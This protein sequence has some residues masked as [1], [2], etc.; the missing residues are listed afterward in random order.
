MKLS[1]VTVS[2]NSADL[3]ERLADSA[4]KYPPSCEWELIIVDN[5]SSDFDPR[6]FERPRVRTLC[7]KDNAKYAKGNNLGAA[8]ARGEYLL[9]VNPDI[10][11]TPGSADILVDF[12]DA[13][14]EYGAACPRLILPDGTTDRSVR[15]FPYLLP[16]VLS[17]F[18]IPSSYMLPFMD[19]GRECDVLQP[20]TSSLLIRKEIFDALGGFDEAFPIFFNDVDLLYRAHERNIRIRYL[21]A[22][23]MKHVHGGSTKRAD[24]ALML[25]ES[26]LSLI[27]FYKKHWTKR[28]GKPLIA[29][30]EAAIKLVIPKEKQQ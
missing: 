18:R 2:W 19:Y 10:E 9:L 8:M 26:R 25:R 3:A 28:Y 23:R 30:F 7:L 27:R 14:S 6:R 17:F 29:L 1:A 5:G 4:E 11:F 22:S 16:L 12:L 21:P 24:P 20:M 15:G 13:H